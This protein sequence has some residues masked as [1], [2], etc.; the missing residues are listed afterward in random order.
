MQITKMIKYSPSLAIKT[1]SCFFTS[2]FSSH[3]LLPSRRGL[4]KFP[5]IQLHSLPVSEV[6]KS[7]FRVDDTLGGLTGFTRAII[8]MSMVKEYILTS[9]KGKG[10]HGEAQEKS[11]T[12]FQLSSLSS[13]K[14][15]T[16]STSVT[17]LVK[18][19]QSQQLT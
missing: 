5:L 1:D 10:V 16:P 6:P 4:L 15:S 18:Y 17:M 14:D 12:S 13:H 19:C 3:S 2:Q 8:L 9:V 7:T 11:G